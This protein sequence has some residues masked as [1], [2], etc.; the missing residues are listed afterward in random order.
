VHRI[1]TP[2]M[3]MASI[4]ASRPG[5]A[6]MLERLGFDWCCGGQATLEEQ[7]R[8]LRLDVS[9]V[10]QAVEEGSEPASAPDS[11]RVDGRLNAVCDQ[12]EFSQYGALQLLLTR[13]I[14]VSRRVRAVHG[15]GRPA[16]GELEQTLDVFA[17]RVH[18]HLIEMQ[19]RLLPMLRRCEGAVGPC[20]SELR[21]GISDASAFHTAALRFL[22]R[23]RECTDAFTAPPD[24]CGSWQLLMQLL[25]ELEAGMSACIRTE[26]DVL[27]PMA[28]GSRTAVDGPAA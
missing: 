22:F 23:M 17:T 18:A 5:A 26:R 6:P 7:C 13:A 4:A 2:A 21:T 27:F 3:T 11:G 14:E 12:L 25:I 20:S 16:L 8:R 15:V 1:I 19:S 24:A 10:I 28:L 9:M